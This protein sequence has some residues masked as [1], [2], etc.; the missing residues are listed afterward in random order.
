MTIKASG[1]SPPTNPLSFGEIETEFGSQSPRSLGAYRHSQTVNGLTF[2]GIDSGIPFGTSNTDTIKFSDFYGKSLNIVV[3][4]FSGNTQYRINAK[5]DKWSNNDIVIINPS[6]VSKRETGTKI[7]IRVNKKIGSDKNTITNCALRTG[8]WNNPASVIVD[9]GSN[10][11]VL[12]SGGNGGRGADGIS[13]NGED[14]GDGTSGLGIEH[15]GTVINLRSGAIIRAGFGGGGGGGGGRETS[16][17]DR[18]AGGGGGG[19]GAGFPI[20]LGGAA[21]NPPS[22]TKDGGDE[23]GSPGSN[24]T[25]T[26]RGV[27]GGGGDNEDQAFGGDGGDGGQN[28]INAEGGDESS[29]ESH[30]KPPGNAGSAGSNGAAIRKSSGVSFTFGIDNGTKQGSTNATGVS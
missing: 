20:G 11:K 28:G 4:C 10:A 26:T 23:I 25:E 13:N 8:T 6:T 9:L 29:T 19:G 1:G 18:R 22:G 5:N 30:N 15:Q 2:N 3:D 17:N 16:K 24:A 27:G 7:T 14:G 12:G 21:G